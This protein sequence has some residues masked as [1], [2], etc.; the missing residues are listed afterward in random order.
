MGLDMYLHKKTYVKNWDHM[1]PAELH[2]IT[3][4]RDGKVRKDIKPERITYIVEEVMYWRK[5]NQIHKWFV[6]NVQEGNDNCGT[7][8]VSREKLEELLETCKL[9]LKDS[10]LV[11][12]KVVNGYTGTKD[13]WE[14]IIENGEK[15]KN[16][17]TAERLLPSQSG[18]FFGGTDYDQY[19]YDDIKRTAE[20]LEKILAEDKDGYGE[21]EYSSSW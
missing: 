20:N 12:G 15:I 19:Y 6:D 18:F 2:K 5:A 7:Y 17:E 4:K 8:Y 13:G 14:P 21:Y 1:A 16:T 9:V 10:K 3:I 11:K